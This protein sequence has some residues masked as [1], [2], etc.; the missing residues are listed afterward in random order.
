MTYKF[1][2]RTQ[3]GR[4]EVFDPVRRKW[5][6]L[7]PEE[8]VRQYTILYFLNDRHVPLSHLSVERAITVNGLTKR[9]DIVVYDNDGKP[10][11]VVECKAPEVPITQEVVEQA[12]RYNRTLR[13]PFLGVTNGRER[14]FFHIDFVT[15]ETIR[16]S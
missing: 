4:L 3:N 16:L 6:A 1:R 11:V 8:Y 7:T 10:A 14:L 13:A 5:V 15:G 9:Y 12:G 2:Q